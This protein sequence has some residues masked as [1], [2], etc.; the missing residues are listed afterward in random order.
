MKNRLFFLILTAVLA[1]GFIGCNG[2]SRSPHSQA[3]RAKTLA[4]SK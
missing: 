3:E 1:A 2:A 4:R